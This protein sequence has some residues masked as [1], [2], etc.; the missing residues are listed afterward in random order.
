MDTNIFGQAV[1]TKLGI[2]GLLFIVV[3]GISRTFFGP[4]TP[5]K[6]RLIVFGSL[7]AGFSLFAAAILVIETPR[8]LNRDFGIEMSDAKA[9]Q[10]RQDMNDL[11]EKGR[12]LFDRVRQESNDNM[13]RRVCT[14]FHE[15]VEDFA[16]HY[17][18]VPSLQTYIRAKRDQEREC[19]SRL[20]YAE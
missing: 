17:D 8:G 11:D 9:E 3:A 4:E 1:Q 13:Q 5:L 12:T 15:L 18:S 19:H 20:R 10:I 6:I 7:F 16:G 2:V 14:E